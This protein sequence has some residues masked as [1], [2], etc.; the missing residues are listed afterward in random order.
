MRD[1]AKVRPSFWLRGTGK[2]LRGNTEAQLL[3]LYLFTCPSSNMIGLYYLPLPT[4]AHELGWTLKGASKAL[5][6]VSEGGLALYDP[7]NELVFVPEMARY[8]IAETLSP[9]DNNVKWVRRELANYSYH[10]FYNLFLE[11]YCDVFNLNLEPISEAPSKPLRSQEQE[12]EQEQ[13][14]DKDPKGSPSDESSDKN[15]SKKV[16]HSSTPG[17]KTKEKKRL[18]ARLEKKVPGFGDKFG[19]WSE[20]Q[21]KKWTV[22]AQILKLR[23]FIEI[24]TR[25][26]P[27]EVLSMLET[28]AL[29]GWS[30]FE[31]SWIEKYKGEKPS[32]IHQ[33]T[34]LYNPKDYEFPGGN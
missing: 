1:Y 16:I 17:E 14:Q 20:I 21:K 26:S 12:Q 18:M 2:A 11:R 30:G 27:A 32:P 28:A 10:R 7:K 19:S 4:V 24:S 15:N 5:Q 23:K 22:W 34:N 33:S 31:E 8:Q 29:R 13:E 9:R 3:A 6:R 25:R